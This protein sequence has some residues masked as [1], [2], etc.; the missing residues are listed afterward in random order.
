M[1]GEISNQVLR[2]LVRVHNSQNVIVISMFKTLHGSH[3]G[4][5]FCMFLRKFTPLI[6]LSEYNNHFTNLLIK[7]S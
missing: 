3:H 6:Y 7:Q 2:K 4:V 1:N 5:F